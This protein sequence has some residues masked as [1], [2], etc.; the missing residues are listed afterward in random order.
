MSG[1]SAM[2]TAILQQRGD[3]IAG[4]RS[5]IGADGKPGMTF[6]SLPPQHQA[7]IRHV[8]TH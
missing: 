5:L 1:A 8:A 6:S 3:F 2:A 4:K 7:A